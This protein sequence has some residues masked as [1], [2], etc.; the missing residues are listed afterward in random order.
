MDSYGSL[1]SLLQRFLEDM[2][3][4]REAVDDISLFAKQSDGNLTDLRKALTY[5]Q[6][7]FMWVRM[8]P[9]GEV[10][11]HFPR[12]LRDLSISNQKPVKLK[13]SGAEVLVDKA[14]IERIY[15]PLVH[16]LRNAFDHGIEYPN[17]R[18]Q[19]GKPEPG[20][21]SLKVF[22]RGGQTIIEVSDDGQGLNLDRIG[23]RAVEMGL[24]T[25]QELA[26]ISDERLSDIIFEPGFSTANQVSELSGRG[27]GLDIV[28][29]QLS[30]LKGTISVVSQP[31][32]GTTF[33]LR[34]PLTLTS[35]DL[36]VCLTGF[37]T[38]A[39]PSSGIKEIL[40]PKPEQV[41]KAGEQWFLQ[42]REE[43]TPVY[44]LADL[45]DYTGPIPDF[46][47]LDALRTTSSFSNLPT[48]AQLTRPLLVI[49]WQQKYAALEVDQLI[50]EQN[51]VI[52]PFST[53]IA[54]PTCIYGCTILGDGSV[55]PVIDGA[56]LLDQALERSKV[57]RSPALLP[58][59]S[60]AKSNGSFA[61]S[62]PSSPSDRVMTRAKS[63]TSK[64][65]VVED[66]V[67]LRQTLVTTL[68]RAGY[69]VLQAGDGWE[70]LRQLQF[71]PDIE[72]V[73]SDIEMPNMNGFDLMN[74]RRQDPALV[75]VPLV[76]LTSRSSEKHRRLALHLGATAY[77]TKPYIEQDFLRAIR[78][79]IEDHSVELA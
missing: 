79:I 66:A 7:D 21:I 49:E 29:T 39:L 19:Q 47:S 2:I 69:R 16:L 63:P 9:I 41:V 46:P 28:R 12:M 3:Q 38:L 54:P 50:T 24:L 32:V 23:A 65:L 73:I 40:V 6:D 56:A 18:R 64:V 45:L 27:V 43:V 30:Q 1:H 58:S 68:E 31:G 48:S 76:I 72:L 26:T 33:I 5:L 22:H 57:S 11:N 17:V 61:I 35:D 52:K 36:L 62:S 34:L 70:A 15:D 77:F 14:I 37:T 25:P 13:L 44:R 78:S 59:Q 74:H 67:S 4:L 55:I 75:K 71:N 42:W 10:L 20:L 60:S 53:I 51:L 8:L